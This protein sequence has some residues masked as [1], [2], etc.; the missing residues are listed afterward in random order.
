METVGRNYLWPDSASWIVFARE[1]ATTDLSNPPNAGLPDVEE[2]KQA[3]KAAHL[4]YV[5]DRKPGIKRVLGERT[6]FEFFQPDGTRITDEDGDRA[7]PQAGDPAR[8]HRMSGSAATATATCRRRGGTPAAASSTAT[9]RGGAWS[10]TRRNT[11]R[12]LVFGRV[13][14]KIRAQVDRRPRVA[15]PTP[16]PGAWQPWSSCWRRR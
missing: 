9:T 13:L 1:V 3:A 8:L 14:P 5:T 2:A 15:R 4:H 6:R 11:S 16:A 7:H 12:M 10:G